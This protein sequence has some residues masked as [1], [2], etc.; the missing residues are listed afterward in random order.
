MFQTQAG[1]I[2]CPHAAPRNNLCC[3][4]SCALPSHFDTVLEF[5]VDLL[6]VL[7]MEEQRWPAPAPLEQQGLGGEVETRHRE[8]Q[9]NSNAGLWTEIY[10]VDWHQRNKEENLPLFYD[11]QQTPKPTPECLHLTWIRRRPKRVRA[12]AQRQLRSREHEWT[13]PGRL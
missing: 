3:W 5:L 4:S 11:T 8:R 12:A 13:P 6:V 9:Q 10:S 2:P 7:C 1:F